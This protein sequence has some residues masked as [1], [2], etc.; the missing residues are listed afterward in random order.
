MRTHR[1]YWE[2]NPH[3]KLDLI[4]RVWKNKLGSYRESW[5][6]LDW[7]HA[8]GTHTTLSFKI[9][10]LNSKFKIKSYNL[11]WKFEIQSKFEIPSENPKFKIYEQAHTNFEL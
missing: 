5:V 2:R 9:Q 7:N 11:K 6:Y 3:F 8:P 1:S 4:G 10:N